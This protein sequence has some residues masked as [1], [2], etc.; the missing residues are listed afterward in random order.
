VTAEAGRPKAVDVVEYDPAWPDW[1]EAI[2][3]RI[4]PALGPLAIAIEHV[5]STSVSGLAAKPVID[6]D[7]VVADADAIQAATAAL[8]RLG[9]EP[10]GDLGVK[11]RQAFRRPPGS[12]RHN[13][14]VCPAG[15]EGLRNHLALRNHLRTHPDAVAAYAALKRRLATDGL[16]IEAYTIAKTD[17]IVSFL[18]AEGIDAETLAAIELANK[19]PLP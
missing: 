2:R 19:T 11:D 12:E 4:A 15:G 10:L 13:V 17:L 3:A 18:R 9:Y 14:Y 16:D 5:G 7:I 1:F 8:E 6:I